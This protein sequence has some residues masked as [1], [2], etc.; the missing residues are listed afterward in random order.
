MVGGVCLKSKST[1]R[2]Y[3]G[4]RQCGSCESVNATLSVQN[5]KSF[6]G[7]IDVFTDYFCD[8]CYVKFQDEQ[9]H[10]VPF[11]PEI[12]EDVKNLLIRAGLSE[13]ESQREVMK[14]LNKK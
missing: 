3:N 9:K 10:D 6:R 5:I 1:A 4:D 8:A 7:E 11:T 13:K 2:K 12:A 14:L